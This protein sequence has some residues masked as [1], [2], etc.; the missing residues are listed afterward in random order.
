MMIRCTGPAL[1]AGPVLLASLVLL[2]GPGTGSAS[3]QETS[4]PRAGT[5]QQ[6]AET[7]GEA[8]AIRSLCNGETDQTWRDYML[9]LQSL[10]APSGPEKSQLT[11]SFN[12]GY[13]KQRARHDACSPDMGQVEAEIAARGRALAESVAR[14]YL[15]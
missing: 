14:T 7:L 1:L 11:R 15:E 10:E 9:Q 3:A 2:G 8:H 6:L 12:N 4:G 13:K 5:L